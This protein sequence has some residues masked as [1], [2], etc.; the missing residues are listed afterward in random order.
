MI[1]TAT[2]TQPRPAFDLI[3]DRRDAVVRLCEIVTSIRNR[4][5]HLAGADAAVAIGQL[6]GH[7]ELLHLAAAQYER[8]VEQVIRDLRTLGDEVVDDFT[9]VEARCASVEGVE[10]GIPARRCVDAVHASARVLLDAARKLTDHPGDE[11]LKAAW[12]DAIL[13]ERDT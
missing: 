6:N 10:S 11:Q 4:G 7:V 3:A 13:W 12:R 2:F 1:T 9:E 8:A 5:P